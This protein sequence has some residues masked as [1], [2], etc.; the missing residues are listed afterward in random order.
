MDDVL[1]IFDRAR[2]PI[3][4]RY[5]QS[6]TMSEKLEQQRQFRSSRARTAADLLRSDDL[7]TGATECVFLDC[8]VLLQRRRAGVAVNRH[9]SSRLPLDLQTVLMVTKTT[10]M[11]RKNPFQGIELYGYTLLEHI[12]SAITQSL[13]IQRLQQ[14]VTSPSIQRSIYRQAR[15]QA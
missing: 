13:K 8:D 15:R 6:V 5:H 11:R 7:A 2:Q 3:D 9:D 1:K 14:F 12:D 10:Q 4:P